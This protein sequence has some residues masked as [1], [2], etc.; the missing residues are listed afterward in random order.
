VT[1]LDVARR[2]LVTRYVILVIFIIYVVQGFMDVLETVTSI[3]LY[4]FDLYISGGA[5][6]YII[7]LLMVS[8]FPL[9]SFLHHTRFHI[10]VQYTV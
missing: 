10:A 5:F 1:N 4:V 3:V 8:I 9:F 2:V 6:I 7:K